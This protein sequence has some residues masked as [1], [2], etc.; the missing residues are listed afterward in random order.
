M[1]ESYKFF[2]YLRGVIDIVVFNG[3]FFIAYYLK[4]DQLPNFSKPNQYALLHVVSNL[5]YFT[6]AILAGI[7]NFEIPLNPPETKTRKVLKAYISFVFVYL[8]FIVATRGYHYSRIF[9]FYFISIGLLLLVLAELFSSLILFPYLSRR[10]RFKKR[11]LLLGAGVLGQI[12]YE[13]LKNIPGYE[14]VGFLDDDSEK[15]SF[16]N[17]K[18]LGKVSELENL[19]SLRKVEVDEVLV[20]LPLD[21]DELIKNVVETAERNC[22]SVKIIPSYHKL[23]LSRTINIGQVDGI[24]VL[25]FGR[26]KLSYIHNIVIKR[27]F[28]IVFSSLVLITV[29]PFLFLFASIGIKLSS[30]GPIFFKQKRKGYRGKPFICYKFRTMRVM[31]KSL[32]VVQAKPNDPRKFKFGDFL[33]RTNLDEFPQFIN[34]LKGEMSVVGPRPHMVE[35]DEMYSKIIKE[36]NVRFFAKP[37]LTGWAQVNGY[38]GATD[39]PELMRKRVEHD[40][41][42]IENWSFGLDIKI[43]LM[44][45]FKM[46]KGDPNAY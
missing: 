32:E 7:Y 30:P 13:K 11:V 31:D 46:I 42:Y 25:N 5:I 10:K 37:G 38:R 9:H 43:I 19:L 36:Y 3:A 22:V 29:F 44:T 8:L 6:S 17:G 33:R 45:I 4:F 41:W 40:I 35:H 1:K 18:Y 16:L 21:N 20:T 15:A 28:D 24:P 26:E 39:D 14:I 27:L 34:V 2:S 12:A 23:F